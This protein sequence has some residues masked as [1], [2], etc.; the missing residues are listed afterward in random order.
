MWLTTF[1]Y[2][3]IIYMLQHCKSCK[4]CFKWWGTLN[5]CHWCAGGKLYIR[6]GHTDTLCFMLLWTTLGMACSLLYWWSC[7]HTTIGQ[8]RLAQHLLKLRHQPVNS[9]QLRVNVH[10]CRSVCP[11]VGRELAVWW[12]EGTLRGPQHINALKIVELA[13]CWTGDFKGDDGEFLG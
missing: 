9:A 8:L 3:R 5:M 12:W 4:S 6:G 7:T 11:W 1:E 13:N 10:H 2:P